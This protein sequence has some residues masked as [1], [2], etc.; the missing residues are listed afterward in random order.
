MR[1]LTRLKLRS[2]QAQTGGKHRQKSLL[3][4]QLLRVLVSIPRVLQAPTCTRTSL[5]ESKR[6]VNSGGPM[7]SGKWAAR[8]RDVL[9]S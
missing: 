9:L 7:M 8:P 4:R 1:L 3:D 5:A 6:L 2:I